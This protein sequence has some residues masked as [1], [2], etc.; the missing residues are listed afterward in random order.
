MGARLFAP[1][2]RAL[3]NSSM[4]FSQNEGAL[5]GG[6][7]T[8][9]SVMAGVELR[10]GFLRAILLPELITEENRHWQIR[11]SVRF[12]PPHTPPERQGG[13]YVFPW[14]AGPYAIDLPLRFGDGRLQ[15]VHPGQSSVTI[16]AGP[17]EAGVATENQWWGPG[18]RNALVLS[19]NAPGFPHVFFRSARPWGT[20]LGELELRLLAGGLRESKFFDTTTANDLRS[21]SAAALALRVR[22]AP[23]LTLGV[24]RSTMETVADWGG[25]AGRFFDA[26]I[27]RG[28][29]WT[30]MPDD[31]TLGTVGREQI[32]AL[33]VRWVAPGSGLETYAEWGRTE[34][35]RNLRDFLEHPNHTQ[36]YTLGLQWKR[37]EVSTGA[38]RLQAEVTT[39]EQSATFRNRPIGSWYTSRGV[40]QG[41]TN[42]GQ[43]LGA[44]IGPGA[45]SQ[46]L[47]GDY[48]RAGWSG[49][50]YL[51][52]IRWHEDVRSVYAWP[53]YQAYCNHDV[54]ILGG[55][56]G[57]VRGRLGAMSL[58]AMLSRRYDAF[59]QVQSGCPSPPSRV[60]ISNTRFALTFIP[61]A[62]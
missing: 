25:I 42:E 8:S 62:R 31:S 48:V 47:A 11:D 37:G 39:V 43:A 30:A 14:Y 6:R 9:T 41:Y 60:D 40:H 12:P 5:W 32:T 35:P 58:D 24:S 1:R 21:L 55:V 20:P 13:G 49:G 15:R 51:G 7:G 23:N 2:V 4:P 29:V 27:A 26:L 57:T 33:F 45:S 38:L 18:L 28:S 50:A 36:G 53:V 10:L 22:G 44:A 52:R 54:S 61:F 34:L 3:A 16:R 56:R 17:V 46:W 19:S 59:F